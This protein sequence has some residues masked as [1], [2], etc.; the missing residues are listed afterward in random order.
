MS[1]L[2]VCII[3]KS[4]IIPSRSIRQVFFSVIIGIFSLG[5]AVPHLEK[6]VSAAGASVAV[7]GIIDQVRGIAVWVK[8]PQGWVKGP[9]GWVKGPQGW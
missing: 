5:Q 3:V 7:Y 2:L 9:Q 8:G 6:F 1:C 4:H